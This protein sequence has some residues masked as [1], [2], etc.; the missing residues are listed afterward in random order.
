MRPIVKKVNDV[1]SEQNPS[2]YVKTKNKL[3]TIL[4][5]KNKIFKLKKLLK[6]TQKIL[7][8]LNGTGMNYYVGYKIK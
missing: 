5:N 7:R 2:T 1:Y 6:K 3:N 8:G 4:E